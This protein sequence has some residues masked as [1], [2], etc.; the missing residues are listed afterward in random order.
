MTPM[1]QNFESCIQASKLPALNIFDD[2]VILFLDSLSKRILSDEKAKLFPDVITFAFWCRKASINTLKKEFVND[3]KLR[4]GRGL[5]FHIAPSNVAV[6]FAYSLI[7]GLLAGNAN[8]VR[9]PSKY[10]EQIEIIT[11]HIESLLACEFKKLEPYIIFVTYGH[12]KEITD[13]LSLLC[14]TRVIWGGDETISIIRQSPLPPRANEITFADRYSFCVINAD[15]YIADTDKKKIASNFYNDTYLTDQNACNAPKLVVWTGNRIKDAKNEFWDYL[16]KLVSTKYV[17]RPV[18]AVDKLV[19]LC[20][21]ASIFGNVNKEKEANNL[22]TRI[23]VNSIDAQ[24]INYH[25]DSGFFMEYDCTNFVELLPICND[26][27]CQTVSYYGNVKKELTDFIKLFHPKGVDRIVPMGNTLDFSL[28][29]DGY[30]LIEHMSR[31]V[32]VT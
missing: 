15:D 4:M 9:L 18:Q 1:L 2:C 17:L 10:Y 11:E 19:N 16:F 29:W 20:L 27:R 22:I 13:R 26:I 32:T 14:N 3:T 5:I 23:H 6:N 21:I 24:F 31:I 28:I 7:T 30:N 8:I 25:T 12:E